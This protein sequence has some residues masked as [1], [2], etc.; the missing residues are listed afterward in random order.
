MSKLNE[1]FLNNGYPQEII[2]EYFHR[3]ELG[4]QKSKTVKITGRKHV[5]LTL[6]FIG[7][8]HSFILSEQIKNCFE[9]CFPKISLTILWRTFKAINPSLKDKLPI[10]SSNNIIYLFTCECL[11]TY[12][13]QTSR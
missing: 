5:Y 6:P 12:V 9:I 2:D 13:G 7:D 3:Y 4:A 8:Q 1:T 11:A 10:E